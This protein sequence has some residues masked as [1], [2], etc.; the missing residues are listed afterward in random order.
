MKRM[1]GFMILVIVLMVPTVSLAAS[2]QLGIYVAPK[3]VYGYTDLG[4]IK[5]GNYDAYLANMGPNS[6]ASS[7]SWGSKSD[8]TFGGSIA[9]GYDFQKKFDIP[10]RTEL[11]YAAFSN[12]KA[13]NDELIVTPNG[14]EE[15]ELHNRIKYQ[16]QTLFLNA[17]WDIDTGTQ[18]TPYFGAGLGIAFINTKHKCQGASYEPADFDNT[19]DPFDDTYRKNNTN[20]AWN[21]GAGLGYDINDNWTI[22]AGYRFVSLGKV[23]TGKNDSDGV[24]TYYKN[25]HIYQHQVSLGVRY[26]F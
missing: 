26:T 6:S 25:N 7:G 2:D 23:K 1:M 22:D 11:E 16:I 13:K 10:I 3:F 24:D 17:Y 9:I 21:I 20:L 5:K 15:E 19:Y 18:F 8:S 14:K 4:K 12:A